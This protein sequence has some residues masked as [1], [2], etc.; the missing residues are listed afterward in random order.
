MSDLKIQPLDAR[1]LVKPIEI[2][3]KTASGLVIP[4]SAQEKSQEAIVVATGS[5]VLLNDGTRTPLEVKVGDRIM[6]SGFGQTIKHG[7][8]EYLLLSAGE[9]W[10][11]IKD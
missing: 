5:G 9:V 7:G 4:D 6:F 1:I 8:E 10:A 11:V 2:E 3:Q